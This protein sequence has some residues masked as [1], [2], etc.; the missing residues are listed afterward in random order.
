MSIINGGIM[1]CID[2]RI[3][4]RRINVRILLR[5]NM[6]IRSIRING[7]IIR[8]NR[9]VSIRIIIIIVSLVV[10]LLLLLLFVLVVVVLVSI[11]V[12]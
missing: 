6:C 4:I 10:L 11:V 8:I 12:V 1:S 5:I 2:I 9:N 3:S 7:G